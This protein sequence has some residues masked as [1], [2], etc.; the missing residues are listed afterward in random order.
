MGMDMMNM[1]DDGMM[2]ASAGANEEIA[3]EV[4]VGDVDGG[5]GGASITFALL[6]RLLL[7]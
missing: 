6:I 4:F 5:L 1:M 2:A 3:I 7:R